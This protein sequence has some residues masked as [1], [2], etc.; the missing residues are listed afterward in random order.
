[1]EILLKLGINAHAIDHLDRRIWQALRILDTIW[2]QTVP[3]IITSTTEGNHVTGSRHYYR[4]AIDI[5]KARFMTKQW[6]QDAIIKLGDKYLLLDEGDH[7]H[8]Q[9]RD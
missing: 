9:T 1:M 3:L 7:I 2:D 5:R 6:I 8:L 4:E